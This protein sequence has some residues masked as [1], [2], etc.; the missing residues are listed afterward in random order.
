MARFP[1]GVCNLPDPK[2]LGDQCTP[3]IEVALRISK[4]GKPQNGLVLDAARD[5]RKL[6]TDFNIFF[7]DQPEFLDQSMNGFAYAW[8]FPLQVDEGISTTNLDVNWIQIP[9]SCNQNITFNNSKIMYSTHSLIPNITIDTLPPQI[10]SVYSTAKSG[11]Y[12]AGSFIDIVVKFSKDVDFSALPDIYSQVYL[13]AQSSGTMLFGV[14]YIE[15]NSQAYV[16]LRG[17]ENVRDKSKFSFLYRVGTGE[18]TPPGIQL[19]L[20]RNSTITLNGGSVFGTDTGLDADLTTMPTGGVVGSLSEPRRE[21]IVIRR[22]GQKF[23]PHKYDPAASPE[24]ESLTVAQRNGQRSIHR[25]ILKPTLVSV[26]F[27]LNSIYNVVEKSQQLSADFMLISTWSDSRLVDPKAAAVTV[28][29]TDVLDKGQIWS[30]RLTFANRRDLTNSIEGVVRTYNTG[31]VV[32]VQRFLASYAVNLD[33]R[34]FPFDTQTF[35]WNLRSTT[36]NGSVVRFVPA[37]GPALQNGTALLRALVDPTFTYSGYNQ[38]GYT[39]QSGIFA[40]YDLLSISIRASRISTMSSTFLVLPLCIVGAALCMVMHQEPAKD[41]RLSVPLSAITATMAF[42]FVVSNQC[43]PVSYATRIH[44]LIFQTYVFGVA[45]LLLNYYLWCIEFARKELGIA[46]GKKKALLTD[47]QAVAKRI[48]AF[49]VKDAAAKD[50]A[51]AQKVIVLAE[52]VH[53]HTAKPP[54]QPAAAA[55]PPPMN[56]DGIAEE[57]AAAGKFLN[58]LPSDAVAA[59]QLPP[60]MSAAAEVKVDIAVAG[61]VNKEAVG[62]CKVAPVPAERSEATGAFKNEEGVFRDVLQMLESDEV[63]AFKRINW[64]GGPVRMLFGMRIMSNTTVDSWVWWVELVDGIAKLV[65]P[66]AITI[67]IA[68]ILAVPNLVGLGS[69]AMP[70]LGLPD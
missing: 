46:N 25:R 56:K 19:D 69:A 20:A 36:Y 34:D 41:S 3:K 26:E 17:Y 16:A 59:D 13:D 23:P 18:E 21:D 24:T 14:P 50:R 10:A 7:E 53:K 4:D 5:L 60:P 70:A 40:G 68:S 12:T 58:V 35:L 15:L 49:D 39:I 38:T 51:A 33:M 42:S 30:P 22:T 32:V 28:Y 43:P 67:T 1:D 52:G 37:A 61:G 64:G 45:A 54:P 44:L 6:E 29:G 27:Q 66:I 62:G 63:K 11:N 47:S 48:K 55:A 9:K 2:M 65:F 8:V 57:A 31:K